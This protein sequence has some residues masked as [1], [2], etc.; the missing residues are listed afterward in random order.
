MNE[1]VRRSKQAATLTTLT[2]F[3]AERHLEGR[4]HPSMLDLPDEVW[5]AMVANSK[6][7]VFPGQGHVEC[8]QEVIVNERG[9]EETV[10]AG[11]TNV[12]SGSKAAL[13]NAAIRYE[14]R[15]SLL[16]H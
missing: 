6:R 7:I 2:D 15:C 14:Q 8:K 12:K 13:L 3:H 9:E 11:P 16:F 4:A 5:R 10:D 1:A